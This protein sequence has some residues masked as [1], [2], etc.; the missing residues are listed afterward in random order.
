MNGNMNLGKR[1]TALEKDGGADIKKEISDLQAAVTEMQSSVSTTQEEITNLETKV[2]SGHV[3]S[4][5]EKVVGTW[6][7]GKPIY[8]KT[9]VINSPVRGSW[10]IFDNKTTFDKLIA[11][12]FRLIDNNSTSEQIYRGL[13]SD[14]N[15]RVSIT[16][17]GS[18]GK[19]L[20]YYI[21]TGIWGDQ[22]V[23]TLTA[24]IIVQYTKTTDNP[25]N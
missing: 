18:A 2:N 5:E 6:I 16:K 11:D 24:V 10:T 3:Y 23:S 9:Y 20:S 12:S 7:N 1:V 19:G 14:N 17:N 4:P 21:G 25:T 15:S 8:Q 22:A 13:T